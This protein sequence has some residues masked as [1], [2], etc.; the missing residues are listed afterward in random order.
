MDVINEEARRR[1]IST[2]IYA[3]GDEKFCLGDW[4][5]WCAACEIQQRQIPPSEFKALPIEERRA[6]LNRR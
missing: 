2:G 3:D 6:Y 5:A 1:V 4:K